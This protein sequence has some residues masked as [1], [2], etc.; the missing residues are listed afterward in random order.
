MSV[1][2]KLAE[3]GLVLA[4][5][6]QG[7]VR[8]FREF[9]SGSGISVFT[10]HDFPSFEEPDENAD[11]FEG[12]ARIK[13]ECAS[14]ILKRPVL[15][16]DSGL[17]VDA[18]NGEPGVYTAR[19]GGPG[20]DDAGRRKYL[21]KKM[22]GIPESKRTARF[23]CIL[24]LTFDGINYYYFDGRA[25]GRI[26]EADRGEDGFGYDPVFFSSEAGKSFAEL[27]PSG[28]SSVSHRG[29]AVMKFLNFLEDLDSD[30]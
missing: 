11:S 30:S 20:L 23:V 24:C 3:K 5:G 27:T 9:L 18:L 19:Y 6:N 15:S 25:E 22:S 16:D 8:E 14:H 7:K 28:K 26:L 21:L 1:R 12:N 10:Y 13:A 29:K 4:T 2:S 17:Q